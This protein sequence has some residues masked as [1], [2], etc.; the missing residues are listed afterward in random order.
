MHITDILNEI[1]MSHQ[2]NERNFK[3]TKGLIGFEIEGHFPLM[4]QTMDLGDVDEDYS[5]DDD[6]FN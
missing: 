4:A 2:R 3:Q 1:N 6:D 5:I